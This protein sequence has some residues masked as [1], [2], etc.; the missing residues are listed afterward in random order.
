MFQIAVT[1]SYGLAD[2]KDDMLMLYNKAGV[3]GNPVTLLLTDNQIVDERFL[4]YINDFLSTGHITDLCTLVSMLTSFVKH[5]R[6]ASRPHIA[7]MIIVIAM[8]P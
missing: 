5:T 6:Y 8:L 3:K 7:H 1:S 2:F 4:V